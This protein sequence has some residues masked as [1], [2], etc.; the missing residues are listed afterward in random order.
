VIEQPLPG[1]SGKVRE[2]RH[3]A[4]LNVTHSLSPTVTV[5]GSIGGEISR[6]RLIG[7]GGSGR[8]F[9][10]PK[11]FASVAWRPNPKLS[12]TGKIERRVGQI[13]FFDF[14]ASRNLSD[15]QANLSNADLVPPQLWNAEAEISRDL[16]AFGSTT[17]RIYGQRIKDLVEL[18]PIGTT[19][20]APGNLSTA[21]LYGI[22]WKSSLLLD[23]LGLA[24]VR[25]DA[26]IQLQRSSVE[27]PVTGRSRRISN[28]LA[29][30]VDL[31]V[32]HDVQGTDWAYG[33]GLFHRRRA[34]DV[35]VFAV[36]RFREGP[37]SANIFVE[38]KDVAG[39]TVRAGLSNLLTSRQELDRSLFTSRRDGDL[40]S[41]ERR[42]RSVGPILSLAISGTF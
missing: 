1:G 11:G 4:A 3:E 2:L 25:A 14:L 28:N 5:Q 40:L 36:G 21:H 23:R 38:H 8:T 33:G 22:D 7:D 20:E 9:R 26:R 37:L 34:P 16:G 10:R 19:G 6:L 24:G 12:I 31:S 42:R 39:L 41:I 13:S 27:D 35:R 18:I 32:R 29:R 17:L 30:L 15:E